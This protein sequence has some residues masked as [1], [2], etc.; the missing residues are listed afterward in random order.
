MVDAARHPKV[1]VRTYTEVERVEGF[2]GNFQVQ[3]REKARYVLADRCNGCG[4]CAPV[5]PIELPN[6]FEMNLAPRKAAYLAYAQAIP[7][8]Y[9]ID[10]DVCIYFQKGGKCKAC[11]K[12]CPT[13]AVDFSQVDEEQDVGGHGLLPAHPR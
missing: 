12:F 10:Q 9:A 3:L 11:E 1:D 8:K 2:V 6:Y 7:P 13:G 5:C 4:E